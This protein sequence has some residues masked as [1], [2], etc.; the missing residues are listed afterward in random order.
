VD[1]EGHSRRGGNDGHECL[2]GFGPDNVLIFS[3]RQAD[4]TLE[5]LEDAWRALAED[6]GLPP[7]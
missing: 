2:L 1:G 4:G 7:F 3:R 5:R 6:Q